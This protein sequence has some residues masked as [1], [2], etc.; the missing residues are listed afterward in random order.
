[1]PS[2]FKVVQKVRGYRQMGKGGV[3]DGVAIPGCAILV[4]VRTWCVARDK[5]DSSD[6]TIDAEQD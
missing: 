2:T 4:T 3:G 6:V 1:M 5:F